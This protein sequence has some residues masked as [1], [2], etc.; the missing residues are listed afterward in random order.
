M[1]VKTT[2]AFETQA[3]AEA[4]VEGLQFVND[5]AI[6]WTG[7]QQEDNEGSWWVYIED[8]DGEDDGQVVLV[9]ESAP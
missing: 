4:F 2:R 3:E 9:A 7:P 5:S 8:T 6:S 1:T